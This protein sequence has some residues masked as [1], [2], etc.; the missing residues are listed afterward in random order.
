MQIFGMIIS[1]SSYGKLGVCTFA[2]TSPSLHHIVN[3]FVDLMRHKDGVC[4]I[5]RLETWFVP[6][7]FKHGVCWCLILIY[8]C[9][10]SWTK[11]DHYGSWEHHTNRFLG[12]WRTVGVLYN[13]SI[14]FIQ[15]MSLLPR[16][17]LGKT[18][19]WSCKRGGHCSHKN[20]P[21]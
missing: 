11:G 15:A 8:T 12:L 20:R 16:V 1:G 5:I 10:H 17:Q 21:W 3:I 18:P 19:W 6:E 13:A 2:T 4:K 9:I 7:D 14:V